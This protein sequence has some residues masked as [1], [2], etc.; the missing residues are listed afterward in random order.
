MAA[1]LYEFIFTVL[2][3]EHNEIYMTYSAYSKEQALYF[4]TLDGYKITDIIDVNY[5]QYAN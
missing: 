5:Y 1:T 3:G 2:D 4:L